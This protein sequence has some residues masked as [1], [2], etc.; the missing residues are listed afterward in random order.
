LSFTIDA[1][2]AARDSL[3][4]HLLLQPL[5]ENAVRH[6][7]AGKIT[8]GKVQII[9]RVEGEKLVITIEDDGVGIDR[10]TPG[11][12]GVGIANT[13]SRLSIMYGSEA[14]FDVTARSG[15][16]TRCRLVVPVKHQ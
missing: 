3:V 15:G 2:A 1:D 12:S 9:A 10:T 4:P 11:D 6:G 5:V 7:I 14:A 8:P 13:Q 16:G